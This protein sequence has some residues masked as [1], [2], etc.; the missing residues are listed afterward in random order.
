MQMSRQVFMSVQ[1]CVCR[2]YNH[3]MH[4]CCYIFTLL[5][6]ICDP[7]AQQHFH[8]VPRHSYKHSLA[9]ANQLHSNV[10]SHHAQR[11][12]RGTDMLGGLVGGRG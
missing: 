9:L 10:S 4:Y 5:G 11:G 8:A 6:N 1:E 3:Y 7:V 2:F 12:C